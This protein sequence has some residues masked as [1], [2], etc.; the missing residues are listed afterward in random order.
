MS[1][2]AK[3]ITESD[4]K[5]TFSFPNDIDYIGNK[6]T[7]EFKKMIAERLKNI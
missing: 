7:K 1:K 5:G 6:L 2:G 4:F 3:A